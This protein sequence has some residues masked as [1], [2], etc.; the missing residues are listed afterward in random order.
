[1]MAPDPYDNRSE[2]E[3]S[4][5]AVADELNDGTPG[6]LTLSDIDKRDLARARAFADLAGFP[7][8]PRT[9]DFDRYWEWL[10]KPKCPMDTDGDGNCPVHK[11]CR[12]EFPRKGFLP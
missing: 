6:Q 1:M 7:W 12:I 5:S 10:R 2:D 9:G 11:N 4:Y 8:P 3:V